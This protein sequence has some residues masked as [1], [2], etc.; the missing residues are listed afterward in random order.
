[1]G[2]QYGK[3]A[4]TVINQFMDEQSD[5]LIVVFAGYKDDIY[6]NLFRVQQ[7]LESR[8]TTKFEIEKYTS[9]ELVQ[10]YIQRLSFSDWIIENTPQLR[11][12]IK[13][14]FE[15]FKFQGRDMDNLAIYTKNVISENLYD[16]IVAGR[17]VSNKITDLRH[18]KK[19]VEIFKEN[20][21]QVED[22]RPD[23]RSMFDMMRQ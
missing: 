10:I 3:E 23:L 15:L 12:L 5:K 13:D 16:D 14:N 9:D 17:N 2:D 19:A 22:A 18:V 6:R 11:E 4:L 8:F 20:M 1:M 21:I 7:G